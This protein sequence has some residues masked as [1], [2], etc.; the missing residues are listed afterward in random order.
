MYIIVWNLVQHGYQIHQKYNYIKKHSNINS[1]LQYVN[2]KAISQL[3]VTFH[4][5]MAT[6]LLNLYQCVCCASFALK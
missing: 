2:I 1:N 3:D 6:L 5:L 4:Y